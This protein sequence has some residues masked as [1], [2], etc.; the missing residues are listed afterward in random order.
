MN[1][2]FS[3]TTTIER[4]HEIVRK[5]N[6]SQGKIEKE[7]GF[8]NGYLN[9]TLQQKSDV[10]SKKLQIIIERFPD[11]NPEWLLTGKGSMLRE[12]TPPEASLAAVPAGCAEQ[13]A[14]KDTIIEAK[15]A[16]IHSKDAVIELLR[17][18]NT[19]ALGQLS[20]LKERVMELQKDKKEIGRRV[21]ALRKELA[22][23]KKADTAPSTP[24]LQKIYEALENLLPPS[25]AVE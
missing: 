20:E 2:L 17:T 7:L 4:I 13:L 22:A 23:I 16:L 5:S 11:I 10:G 21:S 6:Y 8:S 19:T 25:L 24:V 14:A 18:Q 9:T 1:F 15:D 12:G 3:M